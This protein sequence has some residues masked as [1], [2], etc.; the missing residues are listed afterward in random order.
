[1]QENDPRA[2]HGVT[3]ASDAPTAV[4]EVSWFRRRHQRPGGGT[5]NTRITQEPPS[6]ETE[7][8]GIQS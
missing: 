8:D 4:V 5:V 2:N 6:D 1:M 7:A 3:T